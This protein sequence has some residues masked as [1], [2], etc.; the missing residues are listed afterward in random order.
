MVAAAATALTWFVAPLAQADRLAGP[1]DCAG[2]QTVSTGFRLTRD[3][4]CDFNWTGSNQALDLNRHTLTGYFLPQGTGQTILNGSLAATA[5]EYWAS[6]T[7]FTVSRVNITALPSAVSGFMI[8]AGQNLT[9]VH[10]VIANAPIGLGFYFGNGGAVRDTTFSGNEIGLSIQKGSGVTIER[11]VFT[12][13][14]TGVLL[15]NEDSFGVNNNTIQDN[16]FKNNSGS[17]LDLKLKVATSANTG[18]GNVI[19]GN[20]FINSGGSGLNAALTCQGTA[21]GPLCPGAGSIIRGNLFRGN[22]LTASTSTPFANDGVTARASQY[23]YLGGSTLTPFPAGLAGITVT[24]NTANRNADLGLDVA[25]VTDGGGNRASLN[26][27]PAQCDGVTCR[28]IAVAKPPHLT[29]THRL[30]RSTAPLFVQHQ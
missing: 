18:S 5:Q 13:N 21:T 9:V 8:E 26:G 4:T 28:I 20:S 16:I 19:A 24:G 14:Q 12:K 27:N 25:G 10:S 7:D 29:R 15:R 2:I 17:G 11:N 1:G 22:G 23:E 3:V 30:I 6:A